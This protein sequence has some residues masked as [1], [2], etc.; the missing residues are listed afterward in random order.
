ML[1]PICLFTYNRISETRR[2]IE[3]L[4]DNYLAIDSDL[5]IF[6]DNSSDE[7]SPL[8]VKEVRDY[9]RQVSG[10]KSVKIIESDTNKG[11][12][13]SIIYGVSA[14]VKQY[15]KVIVLEDD[16]ITS[17]NFLDYMNKC[18]DFYKE[19]KKILSVSGFSYSDRS[20]NNSDVIFGF[21]AS[22]W[23][24]ATWYDRWQDIDWNVSNY[25]SFR[26]NT[27]KR[28]KFNIGGSDM[29]HMLDKQMAGTINSWAIRF[30]FHQFE[31]KLFDVYPAQSKVENIGIG[32]NAT[33][34]K[35]GLLRFRT[36]LDFSNKRIF[37]LPAEIKVYK[38]DVV[39]FYWHH[40]IFLR[41]ISKLF[42]R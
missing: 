38:I 26:Q 28:L 21:R 8:K 1:A 35:I 39:R 12:A 37:D 34:S 9:I 18:L 42:K 4:Q 25:S 5:I 23:G 11:L 16:L 19:N 31:H 24:W 32:E 13:N 22:S 20:A 14:I 2:T 7:V 10:F 29:S 33:N 36:K 27:T 17:K 40:S 3:A 41:V 30:C 15:N 6:S